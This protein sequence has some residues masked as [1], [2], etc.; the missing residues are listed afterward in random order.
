MSEVRESFKKRFQC[1]Q[2]VTR[3]IQAHSGQHVFRVACLPVLK[4]QTPLIG[5]SASSTRSTTAVKFTWKCSLKNKITYYALW[6]PGSW[7]CMKKYLFSCRF[8]LI[9]TWKTTRQGK[10]AKVLHF[11]MTFHTCLTSRQCWQTPSV[12]VTLITRYCCF[13]YVGAFLA[14]FLNIIIICEWGNIYF[15]NI[16]A[17][18]K[19]KQ[20]RN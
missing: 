16:R 14:W 12:G 6:G 19:L 11:L 17:D 9:R 15:R 18:M 8:K 20:G 7:C 10:E 2:Q 5:Q 1:C 4:R 3:H 13:S